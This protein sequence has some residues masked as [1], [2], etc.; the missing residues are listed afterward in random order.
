MYR[1]IRFRISQTLTNPLYRILN[2]LDV[3]KYF[4][5]N[6]LDQN[7]V[8]DASR[9]NSY[10]DDCIYS[11]ESF[12]NHIKNDHFIIF[13]KLQGYISSD[14]FSIIHSYEEFR[15]SNCQFILLIYDCEF[16]EI[17][18]KDLAVTNKLYENAVQNNFTQ[19]E[20]ITDENDYRTSMDI[21]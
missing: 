5:F 15:D 8:W 9:N 13:L 18:S 6:V 7:E 1:G 4:W 19:I 2:C 21:L 20:Y 16:V 11:G 17:F 14:N 12:L 10:L 3:E